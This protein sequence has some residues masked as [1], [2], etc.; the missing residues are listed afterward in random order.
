MS[1][2]YDDT[3]LSD[4]PVPRGWIWDPYLG[5]RVPVDAAGADD[6]AGFTPPENRHRSLTANDADP[7]STDLRGE[8][9]RIWDRMPTGDPCPAVEKAVATE[10]RANGK[11]L[12]EMGKLFKLLR[13][14]EQGHRGGRDAAED[15]VAQ[16]RRR[17]RDRQRMIESGLRY[18]TRDGETP[19][20]HRGCCG[21]G[22]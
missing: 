14:A 10:R 7:T 3:H 9:Q 12:G 4:D 8:A 22:R 16:C 18:I 5:R 13:L 20:E 21:G 15:W 17:G 6:L 11:P 19:P 2:A 1:R